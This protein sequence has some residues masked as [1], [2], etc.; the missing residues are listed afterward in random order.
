MAE[1]D[2]KNKD[3]QSIPEEILDVSDKIYA[4]GRKKFYDNLPYWQRLLK[5]IISNNLLITI[6]V[7]MLFLFGG[8]IYIKKY[9]NTPRNNSGYVPAS[10]ETPI[11][12]FERPPIPDADKK[13]QIKSTQEVDGKLQEEDID[14][15]FN[16]NG[17]AFVH[18]KNFDKVKVIERN[19]KVDFTFRF[20]I[21]GVINPRAESAKDI[22]EPGLI[23]SPVQF[24]E[25]IS[26]DGLVTPKRGGAGGSYRLPFKHFRNTYIGGAITFPFD[27]KEE[28][29]GVGF[30]K[31]NF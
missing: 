3:D 17:E 25:R 5:S 30:I 10:T 27:T 22:L 7:I 8:F 11:L 26:L 29:T 9:F 21:A 2:D 18:Q 20:G 13:V 23:I 12:S 4:L 14:V 1:N 15:W 28:R 16:G 19:S 6:I 24:F 31:V